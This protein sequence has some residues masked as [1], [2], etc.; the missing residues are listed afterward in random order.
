[1]VGYDLQHAAAGQS[2]RLGDGYELRLVSIERRRRHAV[3]A[4]MRERPRS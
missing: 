4:A 3:T 2:D 1:M